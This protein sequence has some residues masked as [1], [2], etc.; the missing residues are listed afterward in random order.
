MFQPG[1][2]NIADREAALASLSLTRLKE[3][4]CAYSAYMAL[5]VVLTMML[6][7]MTR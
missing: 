5:Q 1:N 6:I 2:Q 3:Q 7:S 4:G